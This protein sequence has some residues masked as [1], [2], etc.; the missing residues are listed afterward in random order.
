VKLYLKAVILLILLC[1]FGLCGLSFGQGQ[2]DRRIQD[3]YIAQ[4]KAISETTILSKIKTKPGDVFIQDVL[5]DDLKRLYALGY[6]TD[7][8]IDVEDKDDGI[9]VTIIVEEKPVVEEV[10]FQGNLK[11]GTRKLKKIMH[12]QPGEMLNYST[13]SQD[14]SDLTALY[15]QHGFQQVSIQY[16]INT[17]K[18]NNTAIVNILIDEK[19]RIR[20]KKVYV[21]GN[22]AVPTKMILNIMQTRPAW[23]LTRGYFSEEV[24]DA[25]MEKLKRYYHHLGYLDAE[26]GA[27]FS[28]DDKDR[29]M[30]ITVKIQ[31]GKRYTA[32]VI[33]MSGNLVF[34]EEK[35]FEHIRMKEGEAYSSMNVRRD[36]D[37]IRE[38]YFAKGY[39]NVDVAVNRNLDPTSNSISLQ[40]D[41]EAHDVVYVGRII[42]KGNTKTKDIVIRR[43]L[44]I[45]PGDRFDGEQIKRSKE[46]IYNL[47]FFEDIYFDTASTDDPKVKDLIIYVKETKTGEFAF[48]GGYSSI[49]EFI[50]FVQITQRNFDLFNIP[51]FTGD[52]QNLMVKASL[53]SVRRDYELSWTEP[54]IFDYPLLFGFD[55]YSRTHSRRSAVGYGYKEVHTGGDI[56]LGKE[57][58]EYFRG[59]IMYKLEEVNISDLSDDATEDLVSERGENWISS[60]LFA[61]TYDTRDN[62]YVPKRGL[63]SRLSFEDAGGIF[64][65]DKDFVKGYFSTSYYYLILKKA[66]LEVK[67]SV[68]LADSYGNTDE[69]PIYERYYA[70]GANTIRGY[71][72][73]RVGP[74]DPGSNDPIGGEAVALGNVELTVPIFEKLIKG[75]IFYDVGNVWRHVEDFFELKGGMKSGAGV[76]LRVKTPIGPLKLDMGYPLSDNQD[77]EKKFE[78]YFSVS[79]GF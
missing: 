59:D 47:G 27:D 74:R 20:I 2:Q 12:I 63:V 28:Y 22:E 45:Y 30:Y 53:G 7:V 16:T 40:Y 50:G 35:I 62:V 76:G 18:E 64:G 29:H 38:F 41:I 43:E 26:I 23:L 42:I 54:W 66:V 60:A 39:M 25:D 75:A 71:R 69:V 19:M 72:E 49:D 31:E 57:F 3:V 13:L 70:G 51:N 52:G 61:L 15:N 79:H 6:F 8:S 55:L 67:G 37:R 24:F 56:R 48:G 77:D 17:N 32:G 5:N 44:R 14:I 73:R 4:N 68:G 58:G 11:M 1:S 78:Y 21:E 36:I 9:I 33:S 65:F 46:R 10:V 34:P